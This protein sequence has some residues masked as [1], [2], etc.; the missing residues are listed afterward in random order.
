MI[1][2]IQSLPLGLFLVLLFFPLVLAAV[3][4]G[5]G[6]QARRR[7][8]L[9]AATRTEHIA[10]AQDGYRGFEGR[11]EAAGGES[12]EAP[13]TRWPCVWYHATVEQYSSGK[14][15]RWT[16]MRD[17]TSTAPFILRD[18]TG[19]CSVEPMGAE[20]TPT[21]KSVWYGAS[22]TPSDR[23]PAKVG[24]TE[25]ATGLLEVAGGRNSR[26]RYSEERIYAGDPLLVMGEFLTARSAA[27]AAAAEDENDED[28]EEND[29]DQAV[30]GD[31][32]LES[33]LDDDDLEEIAEAERAGKAR[34]RAE[35]ITK[36]WIGMGTGE[37]PF[38]VSTTLKAIHVANTSMG[39]QGALTGAAVPAAI[40]LFLLW[41]R[42]AA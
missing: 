25:S 14:G 30:S 1:A 21:D 32:D 39:A 19:A 40:A 42:F 11:I 22:E 38:I 24:P 20:V 3:L 9:I 12:I 41:A 7:A 2:T 13:L 26:Y 8:G 18:Q 28:D 10:M 33:E 31:A 37:R 5:A 29:E 27:A 34:T 23:N 16:T 4:V 35:A 6:R 15:S 17:V 36:A